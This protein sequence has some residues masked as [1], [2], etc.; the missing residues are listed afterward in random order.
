M[1]RHRRPSSLVHAGRRV[2]EPPVSPI[3]TLARCWTRL[4][5]VRQASLQ[6]AYATARATGMGD[7]G[8]STIVLSLL[9]EAERAEP[10]VPP[11]ETMVRSTRGATG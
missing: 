11:P 5:P 6:K 3:L 8:A 1:E 10:D 4:S 7:A 2:Y 9:T